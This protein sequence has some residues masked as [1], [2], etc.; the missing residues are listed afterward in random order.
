[1]SFISL[2]IAAVDFAL[3][4]PCPMKASAGAGL[5][6]RRMHA[7]QFVCVSV[8][9]CVC[10]VGLRCRDGKVKVRM[11]VIKTSLL[12]ALIRNRKQSNE[13]RWVRT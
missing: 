4:P 8:S 11:R 1:M 13:Q 10:E 9:S 12:P 3:G 7:E 5:H 2:L 6:H